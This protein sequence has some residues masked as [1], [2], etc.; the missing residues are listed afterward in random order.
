M[1]RQIP[2]VP[3]LDG[4]RAVAIA[5]V[6]LFH[7]GL[8]PAG[9]MG[10]P[11]FF[12]LSG[13]LISSIL[14]AS[15]NQ[16]AREY[17]LNFYWRRTLRIF[18]LYYIYLLLNLFLCFIMGWS[19]IGYWWNVAYLSNYLIALTAPDTAG[20]LI[21]HLWSLS[22]EEQFYL[23]WPLLIFLVRKVEWLA[24]IVMVS[25]LAFRILIAPHAPYIAALSL[26]AC[27]DL[28]AAGALVAVVK[29]IRVLGAMMLMGIII[30]GVA[31]LR[32][33]PGDIDQ[34]VRWVR[35]S[36]EMFTGLSMVFGPLVALADR[37]GPVTKVLEAFPLV[38]TGRISYG[39][40]MWHMLAFALVNRLHLN[41]VA[42]DIAGIGLAYAIASASWFG[43]ERLFLRLKDHSKA[44]IAL[45]PT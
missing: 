28:L 18:P 24:L 5:S 41:P 37:L 22:V 15:K 6:M 44:T 19:L 39:L 16:P 3:A 29:D 36:P 30:T 12:V 42:T 14:L 4:L 21:G 40:Y 35:A 7:L 33:S 20:G 27:A 31:I 11:L 45:T 10:V 1:A 23:I 26:P 9:W 43:F 13:Y 17:F 8:F 34:T 32:L 38:E 2:Y 25:A